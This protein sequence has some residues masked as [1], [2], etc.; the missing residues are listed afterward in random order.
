MADGEIIIKKIKKGGHAAHH[1]GAWK[2]AYADFVTAMMA[3]FLL[4]WLLSATSSAQK[5]GIAE[6]FTPT[7]GL[8]DS[9]GIGF[10]GGLSAAPEGNSR[11]DKTA[12]GIVVGQVKQGQEMDTPNITQGKADPNATDAAQIAKSDEEQ[13]QADSE[14]FSEASEDVKQ[15]MQEPELKDYSNN[16][17]VTE[18]P[19]GL[20]IDMIDD[21]QQPMF[22]PGSVS[23]TD[24]GKKVLD[25]MSRV[26][27]KT[28]NNISINGHTDAP[29][30]ASNPQY[31][32]WELSADRANAA[33]RFLA[34]TVL[35]KDRVV[36]ILGLS[37]KELLV[38]NEPSNP[39]NRRITIIVLRDSYFRDPKEAQT[40][41]GLITVP[42][43]KL[44]KQEE[45]KPE[46]P[47]AALDPDSLDLP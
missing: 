21:P 14:T 42:D 35:E 8:K 7:M 20:K 30:G 40:T 22:I 25:S 19:E 13:S 46:A 44:K 26:I 1:G 4:L 39:R 15:A 34:T 23:L 2:V 43:A 12:V 31:T 33:R 38:P 29:S 18:T 9:K 27:S 28:P 3:F 5:Q 24:I 6:Y 16:V 41:R 32:T 10:N 11:T 17:V 36:K 47:P 45:K 37:D